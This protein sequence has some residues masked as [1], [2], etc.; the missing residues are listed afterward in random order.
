MKYWRRPLDF[1]QIKVPRG[2]VRVII[3]R[4]KGCGF[5]V[6]YCPK[7]VLA[8]SDAFNVKGYH[9]P[10]VVK[11]GECVNCNLCEMICPDFAIYSVALPDGLPEEEGLSA[12][13]E[14][15]GGNGVEGEERR[16]RVES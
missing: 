16:T 9:P 3:D 1:D 5:C 6:E 2:E 8:M 14:R 13:G 15:A 4:C 10:K 7:D 11:E 12:G